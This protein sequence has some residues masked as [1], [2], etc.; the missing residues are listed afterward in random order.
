VLLSK[1]R[2]EYETLNDIDDEIVNV[3]RVL[4]HPDTAQALAV[5]LRLTPFARAEFMAAYERTSDP[6]ERAR[7]A[8]IRSF[9][10]FGGGG[11]N[12]D[13]KTGFR[14]NAPRSRRASAHDW[15]TYADAIPAFTARL[16]GVEIEHASAFNLFRKY[17]S[18]STLFYLDPPYMDEARS[19]HSRRRKHYAHDM[20][21]SDHVQMLEVVT[22]LKS[23]VVISAYPHHRYAEALKGWRRIQKRAMASGQVTS[24][25]RQ[26]V[27]WLSP[28]CAEE[29]EA[30]QPSS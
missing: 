6:V 7:R 14:G 25:E 15:S 27:L 2:V 9:L 28:N 19:A 17:D 12:V 8:I 3:Y 4:R 10:A 22:R 5:L 26:E 23:M 24:V 18:P 30:A 21:T 11:V 1:P 20:S 16:A 29:M 13:C